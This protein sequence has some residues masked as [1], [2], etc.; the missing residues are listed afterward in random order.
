M[1]QMVPAER[2][3]QNKHRKRQT[4]EMKQQRK[5]RACSLGGENTAHPDRTVSR[6][7]ALN[8]VDAPVKPVFRKG[9]KRLIPE[10]QNTVVRRRNAAVQQP[11]LRIVDGQIDTADKIVQ[12]IVRL[13]LP[14]LI[15][16]LIQTACNRVDQLIA[17]TGLY[18]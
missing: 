12:I 16:N 1:N 17:Q 18:R 7:L 14:V 9:L 13:N 11:S 6:H 2:G 3:E 15:F 5:R 10:R 4:G 8:I